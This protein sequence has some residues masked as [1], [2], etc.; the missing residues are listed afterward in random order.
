MNISIFKNKYTEIPVKEN[1]TG[2]KKAIDMSHV[3]LERGQ[4]GCR[5]ST[6]NPREKPSSHG[7]STW[8]QGPQEM[9]DHRL[10]A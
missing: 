8:H 4:A 9:A 1:I 7:R 5:G 6:R 3:M 2:K 10:D